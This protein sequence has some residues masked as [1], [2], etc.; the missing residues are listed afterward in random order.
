[1]TQ[2]VS[3]TR[4]IESA[5][6]TLT[7]NTNKAHVNEYLKEN[8]LNYRF[9]SHQRVT[10]DT[11][12]K[13]IPKIIFGMSKKGVWITDIEIKKPTLEDVFLQIAR[14]KAHVFQQD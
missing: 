7:F 8:D 11:T 9:H 13:Q 12:E 14:G 1:M 2:P 3:L 5:A 4:K 10:V 6:V